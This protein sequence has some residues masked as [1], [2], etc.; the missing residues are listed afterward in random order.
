MADLLLN[1]VIVLSPV[2]LRSLH[3]HT[4]L[5][6]LIEKFDVPKRMAV[7]IS[8]RASL[9]TEEP[10]VRRVAGSSLSDFVGIRGTAGPYASGEGRGEVVDSATSIMVGGGYAA[11]SCR[12][13]CFQLQGRTHRSGLGNGQPGYHHPGDSGERRSVLRAGEL[14][15]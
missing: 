2:A 14:F 13:A 12:R 5:V 4:T 7:C 3:L 6:E 1:S 9:A 8:R 15:G 11:A 10:R